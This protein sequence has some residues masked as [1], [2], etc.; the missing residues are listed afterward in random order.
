[1]VRSLPFCLHTK[2]KIVLDVNHC[3]QNSYYYKGPLN[4][5]VYYQNVLGLRTESKDLFCESSSY[6]YDVRVLT[7][8]WLKIGLK[9]FFCVPRLDAESISCYRNGWPTFKRHLLEEIN[10]V[11]WNA[12]QVFDF[13]VPIGKFKFNCE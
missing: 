9:F 3:G 5:D 7:E 13:G 8:S 4:I 11:H 12:S 1:M 2:Y 10:S 6:E